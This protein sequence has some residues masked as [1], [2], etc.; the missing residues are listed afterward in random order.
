MKMNNHNKL[1]ASQYNIISKVFDNSR[2]RIWNNVKQ[3]LLDKG[4]AA[5]TADASSG[6]TASSRTNTLLDCGCGNGK[7][8][9][10]AQSLGY[11]SDGFDISNNLLDICKNKGLNVYYQDVLNLNITKKYNKI[12]SIAVLHHLQT[13]EEQVSAIKIL[14][15]CLDNNG[16]LLVSFWSKEKTLDDIKEYRQGSQGSRGIIA[17][18]VRRKSDSRDFVAGPNY[19]SWKLDRENIIQR[20]YYI[21]DYKSIQELAKNI[22]VKYT[23]SWEQQNWFILFTKNI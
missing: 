4:D 21:H 17:N 5:D 23:I 7:N 10:Y 15:D 9:I 13:F 3:F 16:K 8:M 6:A 18:D 2:V 14:C 19:V 1:I 12:I 20:F 22:N 11:H